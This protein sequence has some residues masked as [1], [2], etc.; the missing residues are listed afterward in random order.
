MS[1]RNSFRSD[2]R[3]ISISLSPETRLRG[4]ISFTGLFSYIE[5][6]FHIHFISF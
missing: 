6:S 5:D 4:K 1:V 2:Q 3:M